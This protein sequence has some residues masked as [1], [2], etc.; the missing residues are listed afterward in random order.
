MKEMQETVVKRT[1]ALFL[2]LLLVILSCV[3]A[4]AEERIVIAGSGDSQ[5]LLLA[6]AS[7]F[8]KANPGARIV[9]ARSIGSDGGIRAVERGAADLGRIARLITA[10][11]RKFSLNHVVFAY[12][13]VVFVCNRNV[14][15]V[16]NLTYAQIVGIYSGRITSWSELGG[17]RRPIYV[18]NR[19]E[20][21]SSRVAIE[22]TVPGF[23]DITSFAGEAIKTTPENIRI[24]EKYKDTIGYAPLSMV[25]GGRLKVLKVEGIFP[26]LQNVQSGKYNLFIPFSL[27]WK[28][29]LTG[30]SG[31]FVDF[32]F[33]PR[34]RKIIVDSGAA[35][36]VKPRE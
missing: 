35:P 10:K 31:R 36:V 15:K 20:G 16:D 25:K 7:A 4:V 34:G 2:A 9:I 21:D 3:P 18:A 6:M 27:V 29:R 14:K 13:P 8:E 1:T 22:E 5:D 33:S 12:S 30:L 32:I 28:G 19:E 23:N 24:I 26:S 17:D 11:D